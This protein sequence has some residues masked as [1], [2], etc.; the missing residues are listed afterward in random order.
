[1][2]A[3]LVV[4]LATVRKEL[5]VLRRNRRKVFIVALLPLLYY[6]SFYILMGGVYSSG[7]SVALV[8]EESSPGPYT[9][10]LI[11]IFEEDDGIP[12]NLMI[13]KTDADTASQMFDDGEVLVVVTI[14][15]GFENGVA[16]GSAHLNVL[17]NNIHED[18]TK[19]LRMPIMRKVD[20]FYQRYLDEDAPVDFTVETTHEVSLPRLAYMCWTLTVF[21]IMFVSM[22]IAGSAVTA[23]FEDHTFDEI[24]L[25]GEPIDSVLV[26]K[27]MS[28]VICSYLTVPILLML[29]LLEF[30]VWPHGDL[31]IFLLLTLPLVLLSALVG[32]ALG[33]L[34]K[35][36]V[37]LV[38]LTAM[39]ALCYWILGG[40]LTPLD[41]I[42]IGSESL[43]LF[44]PFYNV[45][46]SL[47]AVFTTGTSSMM[48]LDV[49]FAWAF[50]VLLFVPLLRLSRRAF[51]ITHIGARRG[52]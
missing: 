18:A 22:Y 14:P 51:S 24:I 27:M 39:I 44:S 49:V 29:A 17:V 20:L 6:M 21:S 25:S 47:I 4:I 37:Y 33:A 30:G 13:I 42:G 43:N 5:R 19:N 34:F 15:E 36:S 8:V 1:M 32:V 52:R 2:N 3:R 28:G 9:D 23:E 16:N 11:G 46:R 12:P 10:G 35:N 7:I 26:G 31:L 45:Y 48:L 50:A 38:P 40:G 41:V